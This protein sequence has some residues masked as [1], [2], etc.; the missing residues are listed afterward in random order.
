MNLDDLERF[1]QLDTL[2]MLG[3]IDNLPDQLA[4]AYQLGMKHPLP[5]WK[6]FRQVVIAGMGGSAIGA[7]LLASYC[8]SLALLPVSV[9]R[10]YSLPL[11]ARGRETLVICSSHSGNTEETLDAFESA[12]QSECRIVVVCTG[13]ELEKRAKENN[14]PV[15]MFDHAGQPRAAVGFS[16]GLLLAMFQRLGIIPDQS[17]EMEDAVESMKRT[18][19]HLKADVPAVK[20]PAKRYAGQLMGR[21]V[22][23][24]GSGLLSVVARRWKGQINEVAKAGANFEF[25][26]EADHNTLAGTMNPQETLNAH[27][28][29]LFLRAPSDHPRNRLRSDLTRKAFMLE[30]MNTDYVDARGDTPFAHM[31]TSILFGDY[32]AYYLAM[33]YGVDPTPI[34]ALVEF[35]EA[36]KEAK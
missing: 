35:K 4:F 20:N 14:I 19:Q 22:T 34:Q 26:P 29:T 18:Q 28:M 33:G 16:F 6:D 11:F 3:E 27:T 7:D 25:I 10:D 23:F 24:M 12:R 31:W 9:H 17:K 32:M 1:K 13:G 8:A 15:W 30:G 5:D 21:W 36:M 2:N